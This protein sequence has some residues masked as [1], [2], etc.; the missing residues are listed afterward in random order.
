[1]RRA[2]GGDAAAEQS[3]LLMFY[4][5]ATLQPAH[6]I[7]FSTGS[8]V[9]MDWSPKLNQLF[10]GTSTGKVHCLYDPVMSNKGIM[11]GLAKTPRK[12]DPGDQ[13]QC[14]ERG[15]RVCSA[16]SHAPQVRGPTAASRADEQEEAGDQGQAGRGDEAADAAEAGAGEHGFGDVWNSD[17]GEE[18]G[19]VFGRGGG[20]VRVIA[21]RCC[22]VMPVAVLSRKSFRRGVGQEGSGR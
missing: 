1:M 7:G 5:T 19:C 21:L 3:G 11:L 15:C 22:A 16:V 17:A 10:V 18:G 6:Q 20:E 13:F 2:E 14:G 4:K 8:V 12:S 9:A